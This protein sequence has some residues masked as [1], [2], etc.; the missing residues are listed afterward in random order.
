MSFAVPFLFLQQLSAVYTSGG[1]PGRA[2]FF[3]GAFNSAEI[4]RFLR[5]GALQLPK[6]WVTVPRGSGNEY[7]WAVEGVGEGNYWILD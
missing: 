4:G 2:A 7:L 5:R 6:E 1:L 3:I